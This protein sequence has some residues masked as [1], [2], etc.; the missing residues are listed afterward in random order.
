MEGFHPTG[1]CL[2]DSLTLTVTMSTQIYL[3]LDSA[4]P[5][6]QL[7]A[8]LPSNRL[9]IPCKVAKAEM[10]AIRTYEIRLTSKASDIKYYAQRSAFSS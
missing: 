10:D 3:I 8:E 5:G 1:P 7:Q 2:E 4:S 9:R 6:E